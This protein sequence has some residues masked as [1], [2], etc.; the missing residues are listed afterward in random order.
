METTKLLAGETNIMSHGSTHRNAMDMVPA[1]NERARQTV[2]SIRRWDFFK[3]FLGTSVQGER[4]FPRDLRPETTK[5]QGGKPAVGSHGSTHRLAMD[6]G[7]TANEKG[8]QT[9][10]S[11]RWSIFFKGFLAIWCRGLGVSPHKFRDFWVWGKYMDPQIQTQTRY[12]HRGW[13]ILKSTSN[14]VFY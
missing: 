2:Y 14:C 6:M 11:I 8:G 13:S 1:A 10:Y 12:G 4:C 7:P 9:T 5:L 3:G